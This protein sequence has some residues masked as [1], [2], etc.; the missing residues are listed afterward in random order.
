MLQPRRIARE[1]ALL[2]LS[3][4]HGKPEKLANLDLS[5]IVLE[6]IRALGN[7][8]Q[9]TLENASAELQRGSDRVLASEIRAADVDSAR[10]MVTEAITLTQNAINRLGT[11]LELPEFIQLSNQKEV[12]AYALQII[13]SVRANKAEVDEL[14]SSCLVGWQLNRLAKIDQD[15]LRVAVAEIQYLGLPDKSAINEAVELA[16]RYSDEDGYRFIN[17][18]LRRITDRLHTASPT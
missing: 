14:I 6:A 13:T 15:I 4:L 9:E 12:R 5:L 7:E 1:L 11:A 8:V 3:Q 18:V 17:G 2:S 16:K 10:T